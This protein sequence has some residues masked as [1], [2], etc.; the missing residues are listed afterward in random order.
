MH[1]FGAP[2]ILMARGLRVFAG[3][4]IDVGAE[5]RAMLDLSLC[6]VGRREVGKESEPVVPD[7]LEDEAQRYDFIVE[8]AAGSGAC[9]ALSVARRDGCDTPEP[10]RV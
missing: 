1:L 8:R 2:F 5:P 3:R 4:G 9:R 10:C 6:L 7:R